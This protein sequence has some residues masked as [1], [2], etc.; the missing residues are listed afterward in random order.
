MA[1]MFNY[2]TKYVAPWESDPAVLFKKRDVDDGGIA[3]AA[4]RAIR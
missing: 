3:A 1:I 2:D 4:R